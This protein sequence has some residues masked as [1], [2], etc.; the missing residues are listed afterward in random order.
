LSRAGKLCGSRSPVGRGGCVLRNGS[1]SPIGV[2]GCQA[3]SDARA[4]S[5]STPGKRRFRRCL[6]GDDAPI[7]NFGKQEVSTPPNEGI[8]PLDGPGLDGN[9]QPHTPQNLVFPSVS[10]VGDGSAA[11]TSFIT[12]LSVESSSDQGELPI[13]KEQT[14]CLVGRGDSNVAEKSAC[15]RHVSPVA[16]APVGQKKLTRGK[17]S[18]SIDRRLNEAAQ[19]AEAVGEVPPSTEDEILRVI[20]EEDSSSDDDDDDCATVVDASQTITDIMP[21]IT[22]SPTPDRKDPPGIVNAPPISA[23]QD[24]EEG[25]MFGTGQHFDHSISS[26]QPQEEH[27][28]SIDAASS[29]QE[30]EV[31]LKCVGP[32]WPW[33]S[34]RF[35]WPPR[36]QSAVKHHMTLL[37]CVP[38]GEATGENPSYSS[39]FR[40]PGQPYVYRG[41]HSNPPE[42]TKRGISRGNYAQL[43]R[44]AWLEVSDKYHRYGK[45]LRLYYKHWEG[46]NHP[47]NMFFDW[48]D[49]KGEAAG[50]LLPNLSEC[51]RSVLDSDTVLYIT[52]PEMQARYALDILP[53]ID[54]EGG[55]GSAILIDVDGIP[56][57]TGPDGWIF[58]LRDHVLYG[59]QKVTSIAGKSKERF[60]HSSFFGGKAVAAAGILITDDSGR[61]TRLY[62]H[63]GHYRPGE[64]HMQRM[65][66]FLQQAGVDLDSFHVD[67]QQI[68]HVSRQVKDANTPKGGKEDVKA[69][70]GAA[71]VIKKAK[72]VD[73]LI[74]MSGLHVACHLAHKARMIGEEI[75][76]QIHEIRVIGASTVREALDGI[77]GGGFWNRT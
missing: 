4:D 51:P 60:H 24:C 20:I 75:F 41:I 9:Q 1:T 77:D 43:H 34:K 62:P 22:S 32:K 6:S 29:G 71:A 12:S 21:S 39:G 36:Q 68:L 18:K 47:T 65:L 14:R 50:Q 48:L 33:L 52:N 2:T 66:F 37:G 73:S 8:E 57:R 15:N 7:A 44:K 23:H 19:F 76:R 3:K 72:K 35:D 67:L 38:G 56:V 26:L 58:V 46:L 61:L 70:E 64:A 30:P 27:V 69:V 11:V 55:A 16:L 17:R 28:P 45:N 74:L 40:Q 54:E 10:V 63:S 25:E 31:N 49:S 42:I 5:T 59:A 53:N 13:Q